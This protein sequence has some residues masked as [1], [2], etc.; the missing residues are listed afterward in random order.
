MR[1]E[2]TKITD[3]EII[4]KILE[5]EGYFNIFVWSDSKGTYYPTHIHP[6]DEVRWVVDGKIIIANN[7]KE[8][9]LKPGDRLN[10]PPNTP[11]RAKAVEDV[12]Y[13]C[14]SKKQC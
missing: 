9:L 10:S 6:Y 13:V 11:H 4:K 8:F 3:N 1:Y 14:G 12:I 5:E 7:E 2:E